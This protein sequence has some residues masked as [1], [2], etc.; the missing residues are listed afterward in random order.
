[1]TPV[2]LFSGIVLPLF[3]RGTR[4]VRRARFA[5][6]ASLLAGCATLP[7]P[8]QQDKPAEYEVKA[9]YLYD[10][11]KFIDWPASAMKDPSFN[12]CVLGRDPFG[13][14]LDATLAGETI[15][16]RVPMARRVATAKDAANCKILFISASESGRR[17][18]ILASI[19]KTG[20]LTVSDMPDFTTTGGMI[21]F[22]LRDNKVRFEVNL[23]A[24][25]KAGLTMSSQLLK[26]AILVRRDAPGENV[27]P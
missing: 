13:P 8:A 21:G 5:L 2:T 19:D 22:A 9:V 17:K 7:L 1:L 20:V 10:F 25:E 14:V 11:A 15:G 18:Q 26:V 27:N 24:A 23:T 12:I 16:N 6:Y 4:Q 3:W